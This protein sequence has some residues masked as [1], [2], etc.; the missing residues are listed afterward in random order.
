MECQHREL[1]EYLEAAGFYDVLLQRV[2]KR[3]A[4]KL[5][6]EDCQGKPRNETPVGILGESPV[7]SVLKEQEAHR[8]VEWMD[9]KQMREYVMDCLR[10]GSIK[11]L[12]VDARGDKVDVSVD[13]EVPLGESETAETPDEA[14]ERVRAYIADVTHPDNYP[15]VN[16]PCVMPEPRTCPNCDGTG[17]IHEVIGGV[18]KKSTPCDECG[19]TGVLGEPHT[20]PT[21][22]GY[23]YKRAIVFLD[24]STEWRD[25]PCPDCNE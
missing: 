8:E 18:I 17:R 14:W 4:D 5:W 24:E 22:D 13:I 2:A 3:V 7:E 15:H 25:I 1:C 20:C 10:A 6:Q 11:M 19:G 21:C 16:C 23:G 9:E 12:N